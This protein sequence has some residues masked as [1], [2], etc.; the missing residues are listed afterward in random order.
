MLSLR[1]AL[2]A[3]ALVAAATA[4]QAA[5]FIVDAVVNSTAGGIGKN[6][7]GLT[8]GQ[9]FTV[10]AAAGD[11]WSMG[12]LPRWSNADGLNNS[13]FATGTDESGQPFGT[14]IG[15]N[16]GTFTQ[17][18]LTAA[19]GALVGQI[20]AGNYFLVGTSFNGVAAATG[21]LKL[22]NFDSNN[23]DNSQFITASVTAVPE[24]GTYAMLA[25]GLMAV[26]F[27]ARR[28]KA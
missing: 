21:T 4:S 8:L 28:R 26:G 15:Q 13:L 3:T 25:A 10:T 9:A 19:Y 5:N 23:L 1:T 22:F 7:I 6:T 2:T 20:G 27:M 11:L 12:S 16:F 24:P 17:G 18:G 14:Q